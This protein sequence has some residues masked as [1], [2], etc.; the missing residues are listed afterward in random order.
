MPDFLKILFILAG[1]ILLIRLKVALSL[2]LLVSAVVL[3][4]L[5]RLSPGGIGGSILKALLDP[6][7]LKLAVSLQLIL[8]FS[9]VMKENGSMTRAIAALR[10]LFRDARVTVA[11]IPAIIGLV[12]VMGGAM[13][14]APLVS[15]ASDELELSPE[16]RT[17]LNFWFRHVW[18]YMLPTFPTIF[19][20]ASI[21]GFSVADLTLVNL[22]LTVAS[23]TAGIFFGFRGIKGSSRLRSPLT[24]NEAI[25]FFSRFVGN[26]LPFFLVILF[27][28]YFKIHLAYSLLGV[29]A[30]TLLVS[31]FPFPLL[32]QLARKNLSLELAF[33]IFAIMIFK[34]VL[35]VSGA[36]DTT[37]RELAEM[38]LPPVVLVVLLPGLI[39]FITGYPTAFVGLSFP[40]LLP[41]IQSSPIGLYYVMLAIGSGLSAHLLSPMHACLVMTLQYYNASMGKVYRLLLAPVALLFLT[42]AAVAAVAYGLGR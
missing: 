24:P 29:T 31:R 27:T 4:F 16:R 7:N 10:R 9:A 19:L 21:V 1:I 14:S 23:I 40:V 37:T 18:E 42:G 5:F 32:K 3:G 34:E 13:L 12:P 28:L 11:L 15:E 17:F 33:L 2:T 8:L 39:A 41:F 26:L 36:M 6:E 20:T 35:L 25:R 22:P 30:G 38:G